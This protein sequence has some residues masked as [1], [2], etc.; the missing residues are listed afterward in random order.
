[1]AMNRMRFLAVFVAIAMILSPSGALPCGPMFPTAVF[2]LTN[3]PDDPYINYLR[4]DLGVLQPGYRSYDLVPAYRYLMGI[5]M[6]NEE[7]QA[8]NGKSSNQEDNR[9]DEDW[10]KNWIESRKEIKNQ[11]MI[12]EIGWH[13]PGSG[14]DRTGTQ[15]DYYSYLNCSEDAFKTAVQTMQDRIRL[16]GKES[17]EILD[18]VKAQDTVFSNCSKGHTI[19][20]PPVAGMHLLIKSDRA[21][22]IAAANFYAG[23]FDKAEILFREIAEDKSSPWRTIAPYLAARALVRNA[24]LKGDLQKVGASLLSRAETT[25]R[26]IVQ[27]NRLSQYHK[28]AQDLL[29]YVKVRLRPA[30]RMHEIALELLRKDAGSMLKEYLKEYRYMLMST[31]HEVQK[32]AMASDDVTDWVL[33]F[34]NESPDAFEHALDRWEKTSSPAWLVAAIAKMQA[35]H[36]KQ[37]KLQTEADKLMPDSPAYQTAVYHSLR[38]LVDSGKQDAARKR[39]DSLLIDTN[40][41][42]SGS[43]HNLLLAIRMK[44]STTLDDFLRYAQRAPAALGYGYDEYLEYTDDKTDQK[45]AG[46]KL[47]DKD[48][49]EIVNGYMPLSM[50]SSMATNTILPVEM[51]KAIAIA[52][53]VRAVIIENDQSAKNIAPLVSA[54]MPEV[55]QLLVEYAAAQT[56]EEGR[57]I[58]S[59]IMLKYPGMKPYLVRGIGRTTALDKIDDYRDNWWCPLKNDWLSSLGNETKPIRKQRGLVTNL[60]N[61]LSSYISPSGQSKAHSADYPNFISDEMIDTTEHEIG[62]LQKIEAGP[63]YLSAIVLPW[64]ANKPK[65]SRV[66]EALHLLVKATRYGCADDETSSHSK[67]AFKLLHK[68]Y[69]NSKWTKETPYYF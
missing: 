69:P 58:A 61:K 35:G 59:F 4:G 5:G 12:P 46:R 37:Q 28:P 50:L 33:T 15:D 27:D 1:M 48:S 44:I 52:A 41:R 66:P 39:L 8:L 16:F 64:A 57:F 29:G 67:A 25:L 45:L 55:K 11:G 9:Q 43:S 53:W 20:D 49:V 31:D 23:D 17:P 3:R 10:V 47:L 62:A 42:F 14:V 51:R 56:R 7:Q 38:L 34:Q 13:S 63:N 54:L 22:Q 30:E 68:K 6:N 65:D 26:S 40:Q 60:F 32:T 19:P 18:W 24:T 21:Y 36:P 2:T